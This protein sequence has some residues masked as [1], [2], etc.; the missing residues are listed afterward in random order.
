MSRRIQF[1]KIAQAITAQTLRPI[2]D[3]NER[4]ELD[5]NRQALLIWCSFVTCVVITINLLAFWPLIASGLGDLRDRWRA[6]EPVT[7]P[8]P[9]APRAPFDP[10]RSA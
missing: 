6:S 10:S 9:E 5:A 1:T 4:R 2:R 8:S 3:E 7:S